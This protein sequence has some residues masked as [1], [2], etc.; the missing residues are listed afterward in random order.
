MKPNLKP[1]D[2]KPLKLKCGHTSQILLSINL[3]RYNLV[4]QPPDSSPLTVEIQFM[5]EDIHTLAKESHHL[6]TIAR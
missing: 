3:R 1:P 2:T 5:H 4:F 6:Y